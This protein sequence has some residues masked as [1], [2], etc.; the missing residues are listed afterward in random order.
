[1]QKKYRVI[2]VFVLLF[3][4]V[5][6][7]GDRR[8]IPLDLFLIIDGSSTLKNVQNAVVRWLN[9]QVVDRILQEGDR[10]TIWIAAEKG[11]LVFSDTLKGPGDK[12]RIKRLFQ[13]LQFKEGTANFAGVLREATARIQQAPSLAY[14]LLV[15]G[16]TTGRAP[17]LGG[18]AVGLLRF[19]RV[20]E[21]SGWRA[22]VIGLG[23]T[24]RVQQAA[25][26]YMQGGR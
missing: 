2:L 17:S 11:E 5:L 7:A 18:D 22:M 16:S 3:P 12:A 6:G 8:N 25:A 21:F 13:S 20:E 24:T 23:L 4:R 14:T 19:T 10:I 26:A 15:S 1:M 9:E